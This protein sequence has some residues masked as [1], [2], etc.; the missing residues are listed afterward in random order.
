MG[1]P[2]LCMFGLL[3]WWVWWVGDVFCSICR[4][5][6]ILRF[7]VLVLVR[8]VLPLRRCMIY[9]IKGFGSS[10]LRG[11]DMYVMILSIHGTISQVRTYRTVGAL[12]TID[13]R[14]VVCTI[15][16]VPVLVPGIWQRGRLRAYALRSSNRLFDELCMGYVLWETLFEEPM[17]L[18]N[19]H[20]TGAC[21]YVGA[22]PFVGP[23]CLARCS[24]SIFFYLR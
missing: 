2:A 22:R 9:Y 1:Y 7:F 14:C 11:S 23:H 16:L 10:S 5:F 17:A 12:W 21:G 3:F 24:N 19:P 15:G 8:V 18:H 13:L 20:T 6:C 4:V